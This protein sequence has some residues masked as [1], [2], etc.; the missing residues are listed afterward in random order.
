MRISLAT[1]AVRACA[2]ATLV[3]SLGLAPSYARMGGHGGVSFARPAVGIGHFQH[4]APRGFNQRF[5]FDRFGSNRFGFK[6]FDRFGANRFGRFGLNRFNRFDSNR[7]SGNQLLVGGWGWGG[8]PVPNGASEPII[9]GDRA[10][11]IINVGAG[12]APGAAAV[13]SAGGCVIHKLIYD[14]NGKYVGERQS[15]Q[16]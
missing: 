8:A 3:F 10:P 11:I 13:G 14:S 4:F 16:C 15:P 1:R 9:V 7:F 5:D 2:A 12:P 6:R